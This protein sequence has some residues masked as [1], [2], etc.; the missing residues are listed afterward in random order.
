MRYT[1]FFEI[2]SDVSGFCAVSYTHLED[3][4]V[5]LTYM[6]NFDMSGSVEEKI[7]CAN[8]VREHLKEWQN[9]ETNPQIMRLE[10]NEM[11]I[12]DR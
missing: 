4:K 7:A 9:D 3:R 5:D 6:M 12:R 10:Y 11:C 8:A 1:I 2:L